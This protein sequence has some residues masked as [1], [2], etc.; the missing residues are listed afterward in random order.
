MHISFIADRFMPSTTRLLVGTYRH[1]VFVQ[2]LQWDLP[3]QAGIEQDDFDVAAAVHV[4]VRGDDGALVGYAR[5]LPTTQRYL[6]ATH[7]PQLIE[8]GQPVRS[9]FVWELSRY[10]AS[11]PTR[12]ND[13][14]GLLVQTRVGKRLLLEATR[15]VTSQGGHEIVFCTTVPIERLALRW[16]VDIERLGTP[17]HDGHDWLVGARIHCNQRTS[18]ALVETQSA[19]TAPPQRSHQAEPAFA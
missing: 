10:A 5:L 17:H 15:F 7:F 11:D 12:G 19:A 8:S 6:L 13:T 2:G 4:L 14:G 1:Q 3:A 9:P 16:G 18:D